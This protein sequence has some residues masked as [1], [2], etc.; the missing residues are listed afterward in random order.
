MG[1]PQTKK[2]VR[3]MRKTAAMRKSGSEASA[4]NNNNKVP[5][6]GKF[7]ISQFILRENVKSPDHLYSIANRRSLDGNN[8]L[9][10][11]CV[12][13]NRKSMDDLSESTSR[14]VS[15]KAPEE[16]R[17]ITR[18]EVIRKALRGKCVEGC[19]RDWIRCAL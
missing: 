2:Y 4:T 12:T 10:K 17:G 19:N 6:L 8:N 5:R 15:A 3:E 1:S 9:A 7:E 11:F 16:R 14:L 13:Q 18:I